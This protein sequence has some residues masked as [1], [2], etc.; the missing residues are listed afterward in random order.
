[1]VQ[2]YIRGVVHSS[3]QVLNGAFA[4]LIHPEDVVVDVRDAINEV[5]EDVNAEGLM[6]PCAET[7]RT[8][9]RCFADSFH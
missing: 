4:E 3:R 2:D 8:C 7:E 5:L 1:M 9:Y 6:D